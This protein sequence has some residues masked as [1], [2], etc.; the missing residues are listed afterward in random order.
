MTE[1]GK[2]RWAWD[3]EASDPLQPWDGATMAVV[4]SEDGDCERFIG[5]DCLESMATHMQKARGTYIAHFGGGYDVPLLL[6]YWRPK[7]IVLSGSNI[8]I[9]EDARDLQLRDSYPWWLCSLAKIGEACGLPKM[10]VDRAQMERLTLDEQV[11]YCERDVDVLLRGVDE[12]S[13][14]LQHHGAKH[15]WTAGQSAARLVEALEPGSWRAL[16]ANRCTTVDVMEML[17]SG[18]VRGGRVECG[19]RGVVEGVH[20]YDIKSSYPARYATRDVGIGLR[21][22]VPGDTVGVWR[23]SWRWTD[24]RRIPPA[25][26]QQTMCGAGDCESWLIDDEITAFESCGVKVTRHEGWAADEVLPI[27]QEFAEVMYRAKEGTGPERAFSKVFLN[28]W[29]G[30]ATMSPLQEQ[31]T[32]WLPKKYWEPGGEPRRV[33]E[34]PKGGWWHRYLTLDGDKNGLLRPFQQ[35]I[36]GALI[37]GRARVALWEI[38]DALYRAGWPVLYNDTDSVMTTCPP[39]S[40]PV[41]LGKELGQLAYEGGPFT[42]YF[43]GP[44]AY[45]LTDPMTGQ[46]K[47]CALKG[48]PHKSYADGIFDGELFREARGIERLKGMGPFSRKGPGRDV[49]VQLFERALRSSARALKDGLSTFLTGARGVGDEDPGVWKRAPVIRTIR[50]CGRGKFHET[51]ST[52]EYLAT[53]E[54]NAAALLHNLPDTYERATVARSQATVDFALA[55][56]LMVRRKDVSSLPRLPRMASEEKGQ[57]SRVDAWA[58]YREVMRASG[59]ESHPGE[60]VDRLA[61]EAR[62]GLGPE[63]EGAPFSVFAEKLRGPFWRGALNA[64][65]AVREHEGLHAFR[66]P[67]ALLTVTADTLCI[68]AKGENW[69][70]CVGPMWSPTDDEND[71]EDSEYVE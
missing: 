62:R 5:A 36:M 69:L 48:V 46:V 15:A 27:G 28:A 35:P 47:K 22:A 34:G 38:D 7:K 17:T 3:V 26:D 53:I 18:A 29:H 32:A 45:C 31:F 70:L 55:K 30:K 61:W 4:K 43:L 40:M 24:R 14:F 39:E 65:T 20:V 56:G 49:R 11:K 33:P 41:P 71:S 58:A 8:L 9:A 68:T 16:K 42:A 19:A 1:P 21:R 6:N 10:D 23:C 51:P 64:A 60:L 67:L 13:R 12:A 50:P 63:P 52:Y 59:I 66:V 44:K 37:L 57:R 25:L 54:V 2:R